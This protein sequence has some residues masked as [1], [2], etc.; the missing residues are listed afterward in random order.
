M[1]IILI[2]LVCFVLGIVGKK[3]LAKTAKKKTVSPQEMYSILRNKAFTVTYKDLGEPQTSG[4]QGAYGV[5]METVMDKAVVSLVAFS[6]GDAS[7]YFSTGGGMIGGVSHE[8]VRK[9]AVGFSLKAG[10]FLEKCQ[11]TTSFPPPVSG[12]VAF[13]IFTKEGVYTVQTDEKNFEDG[14]DAL[15]PLF[16]AGQEVITQFRLMDKDKEKAKP[17]AFKD[18]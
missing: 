1:R 6:T 15:A 3:V 18:N 11:K 12:K 13:Y 4:K 10:E 7:L 8:N 5:L 14:K 2:I 16:F 17:G 9:A